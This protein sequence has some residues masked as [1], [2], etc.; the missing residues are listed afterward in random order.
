MKR[1]CWAEA[2]PLRGVDDVAEG[3]GDAG[4]LGERAGVLKVGRSSEASRLPH[5]EQNRPETGTSLP[6]LTQWT[7]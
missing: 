5:T 7:T 6:Q 3:R 2:G 4:P 1:P